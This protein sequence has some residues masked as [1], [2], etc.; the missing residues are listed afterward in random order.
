MVPERWIWHLV[1]ISKSLERILF[2]LRNISA[3]HDKIFLRL[4][5]VNKCQIFNWHS[6]FDKLLNLLFSQCV[7]ISQHFS[8]ILNIWDGCC[9]LRGCQIYFR[10]WVLI[11]LWVRFILHVS[12]FWRRPEV[13]VLWDPHCWI[14]PHRVSIDNWLIIFSLDVTHIVFS[15][16]ILLNLRI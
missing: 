10:F 8:F 9:R 6:F 13:W 12:Q 15:V 5:F 1:G 16:K 14:K 11:W 3:T 2:T 4:N 7:H